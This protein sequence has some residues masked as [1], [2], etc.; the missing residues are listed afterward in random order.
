NLLTPPVN[1]DVIIGGG[2]SPAFPQ[3]PGGSPSNSI[4]T[5][6]DG[7]ADTVACETPGG[8]PIPGCNDIQN[9]PKG[10]GEPFRPAIE[11]GPNGILDTPPL[12]DDTVVA[13]PTLFVAN[14][15]GTVVW[16]DLN[17][18]DPFT[19]TGS[20]RIYKPGCKDIT[21]MGIGNFLNGEGMQVLLTT[22]DFGGAVVSFDPTLSDNSESLAATLAILDDFNET[23]ST[24]LDPSQVP[25]PLPG[26]TMPTGITRIARDAYPGPDGYIGTPDDPIFG[27]PANIIDPSN[28]SFSQL[29]EPNEIST[30]GSGNNIYATGN[31]DLLV[32]GGSFSVN[33]L[34]SPSDNVLPNDPTTDLYN[35]ITGNIY[36][37]VG[38]FPKRQNA[39]LAGPDLTVQT[40]ACETPGGAPIAGCDDVQLT[41]AGD[42]V[43][44]GPRDMKI[45]AGANGVAESGLGGDDVQAI[46]VGTTF[47][48]LAFTANLAPYKKP[49]TTV[50][51]VTAGGNGVLDTCPGRD[52][53][54]GAGSTGI[55][56]KCPGVVA[57]L[58][59]CPADFRALGIGCTVPDAACPANSICTGPNGI[60]D[61]GIALDDL[62]ATAPAT[63]G[64]AT[65]AV[66]VSPGKDAFIET[67][68][69][70]DDFLGGGLPLQVVIEPGPDNIL[71]TPP[72]PG[73]V[74]ARL[75]PLSI[76]D[77]DVFASSRP[78]RS[79]E[80]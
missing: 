17:G 69:G 52:D 18:A 66:V 75:T 63:T 80:T 19:H 30:D 26:S 21:G 45:L 16:M 4:T 13:S 41:L 62:Q 51:G 64:L 1:D 61:S 42:K 25:I 27:D 37:H 48:T 14:G 38:T 73:D 35:F 44:S 76:V 8:A 15:D 28:I 20:P 24:K 34:N 77:L 29:S 79:L 59:S 65:T 31:R 54:V 23:I 60:V 12:G 78:I 49:T 10:R 70:G 40:T 55:M 72:A 22:T 39:V 2:T 3:L 58:A 47:S 32:I 6:P 71:Q 43:F 9:I 53:T 74:S 33:T 7:I 67:S 5:G 57:A 46:P 11:P 36:I 68:P 56:A 50:V